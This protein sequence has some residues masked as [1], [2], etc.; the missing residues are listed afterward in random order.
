ME[1][2]GLVDT[3]FKPKK[4]YLSDGAQGR[5][6]EGE[7]SD[8]GVGY[9]GLPVVF[10]RGRSRHGPGNRDGKASAVLSILCLP[11]LSVPRP[12]VSSSPSV[13]FTPLLS[14]PP[15]FF[16]FSLSPLLFLS[17]FLPTFLS[18]QRYSCASPPFHVNHCDVCLSSHGSVQDV[19]IRAWYRCQSRGHG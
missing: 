3:V 9:S 7:I 13:P 16:F 5:E 2:C 14:T 19:Q 17:S 6:R 15:L 12:S 10:P 11:S 4:F 18:P 8:K 1:R